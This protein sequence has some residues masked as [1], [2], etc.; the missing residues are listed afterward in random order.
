MPRLLQSW[1]WNDMDRKKQPKLVITFH[2]TTAAM[3]M[4]ASCEPEQGRLIPI[5]HEISGSCGLAWC[6]DPQLEDILLA[7][8]NKKDIQYHE[9]RVILLY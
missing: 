1:D 4:E 2:T 5:P 9:K 7:L 6:A 3:E 8:M